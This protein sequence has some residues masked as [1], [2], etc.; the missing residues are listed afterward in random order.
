MASTMKPLE[1]GQLML[2]EMVKVTG[3]ACATIYFRD[4]Q[5]Q[6]LIPRLFHGGNG[7]F[8]PPL[9]LL[10]SDDLAVEAAL[11]GRPRQHTSHAA[12]PGE[13]VFSDP[14][15]DAGNVEPRSTPQC[16]ICIPL[17]A[18]DEVLGVIDLRPG[19]CARIDE[20]LE[21]MLATLAS[22]AAVILR[23]AST[24]SELEQHYREISLLYEIQQEISST[25]DYQKVLSLIVE[26][27]KSLFEAAECTI[28]LV[29]KL[30]SRGRYVRI[31]ATTGRRFI[32]PDSLPFD[33]APLDR[34]VF[35]GDIIY[36][37]D[38][39]T[40]PRF[41]DRQDAEKVGVVSL[42]C[43]PLVARGRTIGSLRVYTAKRRDF[44]IPDRK[45]LLAVA[46][47]AANAIDNAKLYMQIEEKN[48]ELSARNDELRRT[49]KE[50]V[51]REKLAALGEMA[52]TVAHE[53]RNPLTSVRGFA[54]RISRKYGGLGDGRLIQYTGIIMQEVDRLNKFI[55]DVLDFARR[56]KPAFELT[57]VNRLVADAVNLMHDELAEHDITVIPDFDMSLRKTVLDG[58][59]LTQALLNVLQNARQAMARGGILTVRTQNAGDFLR[60]RITDSGQG[61]SREAMARIWTPFYTS[62][63]QG[64]GLG[65]ALVQR[66]IDDHHGRVTI[67]SRPGL[68]TIV[69]FY[70]PVMESEEAFLMGE[71][72]SS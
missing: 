25:F 29:E 28:R 4:Q 58:A 34:Q 35:G 2:D 3:A 32:G 30:P 61:I 52:A 68:G 67:R 17:V 65:L 22:Q 7:G 16:R 57:D 71:R 12:G 13:V 49:Q 18:G 44:S 9:D 60:V 40:D 21:E 50:L 6:R 69:N 39:R 46:G 23:N 24:H 14:P 42:I 20:N 11:T 5:S 37:E 19:S 70:L 72:S 26:R 62:K 27:T 55:K 59:L 66:I 36:M 8:P 15:C 31:V 51:K 41:P 1:I 38:V 47:L 63:T 56:A 53:I 54:Q 43:A 48:R 64:T 45:M 10:H 33:Q